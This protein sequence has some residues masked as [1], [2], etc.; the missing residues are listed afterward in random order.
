LEKNTINFLLIMPYILSLTTGSTLVIVKDGT[1]DNTTSLTFLGRN[2]SGYGEPLEE[3]FIKLL[4]NFSSPGESNVP[5]NS[6]LSNPLQGQLWFNSTTRQLYVSY[7]GTNFKGLGSITVGSKNIVDNPVDGDM[8]WDNGVLYG[9]QA[10]SESFVNIGPANG[11]QFSSWL[12]GRT[13]SA[14]NDYLL[15]SITGIVGTLPV[16]VLSYS[17]YT[18]KNT[19]LIDDNTLNTFTYIKQG[20][21]LPNAD[22]ITGVSSISTDTGYLLWGTAADAINAR[23]VSVTRSNLSN[24]NFY[25]PLSNTTTGRV[26]LVT[27][28]SFYYTNNG[29]LNATATAAYYADLAERYEADA[30]YDEGT[31]LIIGGDKEVTVTSQFA[32]TRVAGIVSKNPAYLMNKDAGTD[33][34]HPAIALKGRVPCKVQGYIKKG[35]LIVTSSTPGYG[36][37]ANHVF[38]GAIVG[39]ALEEHS[40]GFGIIEVLVV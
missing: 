23:N 24:N 10:S 8:F 19:N 15:P 40:E 31:V 20:I 13:L 1:V 21:T 36:I 3:N 37:A 26:G 28:S 9:Y 25:I 11:S 38:G 6:V 35:D 12:Y 29:V 32:D 18:P 16:T 33:E 30:V 2:F 14:P 34:S 27:S 22:P 4:E 39:K 7:D 5:L 17:S